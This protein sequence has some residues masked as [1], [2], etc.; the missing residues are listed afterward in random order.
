MSGVKPTRLSRGVWDARV[1]LLSGAMALVGR[2]RAGG[3]SHADPVLSGTGLSGRWGRRAVFGVK[4]RLVLAAVAVVLVGAPVAGV[5]VAGASSAKSRRESRVRYKNVSASKALALL[6]RRLPSAASGGSSDPLAGTRVKRFL[7]DSAAVVQGPARVNGLVESTQPLAGRDPSGAPVALNLDLRAQ[8]GALVGGNVVNAVRIGRQADQG[9][10]L[11]SSGVSFGFAP[12]SASAATVEGPR[13]FFADTATD[14]DAALDVLPNGV[15]LSW[16]LRSAD[17]PTRLPLNFT[18]PAGA[19]VRLDARGSSAEVLSGDRV[20]AVVSPASVQD[21]RGRAV[22]SHFELAGQRLTLVVD[23]T[24]RDLTYPLIADPYI[25]ENWVNQNGD[26]TKNWKT[27]AGLDF[28]GWMAIGGDS[29]V[30]LSQ[31][32]TYNGGVSYKSGLYVAD[33]ALGPDTTSPAEWRWTAPGTSNIYRA[34]FAR[35]VMSGVGCLQEGIRKAD[36]SWE[37]TGNATPGGTYAQSQHPTACAAGVTP[38]PTN[39]PI[40]SPGYQLFCSRASSPCDR[41]TI[42]SLSQGNSAVFGID[43]L[44]AVPSFQVYEMGAAVFLTD[45]DNPMIT[46]A[47]NSLSGAVRTGTGTI[48]ATATDTGLGVK[49]LRLQ[50]PSTTGTPTVQEQDHPCVGDR[51]DRCPATWNT[52]RPNWTPTFAS[53]NV[54]Q[55]PEGLNQFGLQAVDIVANASSGTDA[56][57]AFNSSLVPTIIVDRTP[58]IVAP[59]GPLVD[60]SS[61]AVGAGASSL[62]V[63][64]TDSDPNHATAGVASIE[65]LIDGAD[66]NSTYLYSAPACPS[67]SCNANHTFSVDPSALSLGDHTLTVKAT[68][69]AG[70]QTQSDP[71]TFTYNPETPTVSKTGPASQDGAILRTGQRSFSIN[72]T[73]P[74]SGQMD[75]FG[76][77]SASLTIDGTEFQ[78]LDEPCA[79]VACDLTGSYELDEA[80]LADGLHQLSLQTLDA[81]GNTANSNWTVFTDATPPTLSDSGTLKDAAGSATPGSSYNLHVDATDGSSSQ[82]GSGVKSVSV[83]VDGQQV[84]QRSNADCP[85]RSC[86]SSLDYTYQPSQFAQNQRHAIDVEVT[87]FAGNTTPD[88]FYVNPQP[89]PAISPT[90]CPSGPIAQDPPGVLPVPAPVALTEL[91]AAFPPAVANST[92][93]SVG[94][95]PGSIT[96]AF[97]LGGGGYQSS[98]SLVPAATG[99]AASS[100]V[101]IGFADAPL[102]LIPQG[103]SDNASPAQLVGNDALFYAN[104]YP[105]TDLVRRATA[106]G[107]EDLLALRTAQAPKT[108]QWS[109]SGTGSADALTADGAN[110]VAI[111]H[112]EP[113]DTGAGSPASTADGSPANQNDDADPNQYKPFPPAADSVDVDQTPGIDTPAPGLS[114]FTKSSVNDTGAQVDSLTTELNATQQRAPLSKVLA[115][116]RAAFA[117]DAQGNSVPVSLQSSGSTLT[118]TVSPNSTTVYPILIDPTATTYPPLGAHAANSPLKTVVTHGGP[119]ESPLGCNYSTDPIVATSTNHLHIQGFVKCMAKGTT[120]QGTQTFYV[121]NLRLCARRLSR[122]NLYRDYQCSSASTAAAAQVNQVQYKASCFAGTNS[123]QARITWTFSLPIKPGDPLDINFLNTQNS[124]YLKTDCGDAAAWRKAAGSSPSRT[125]RKNLI[126]AGDVPDAFSKT[127]VPQGYFDAHHIVPT[128]DPTASEARALAYRCFIATSPRVSPNDAK[129][130]VFLRGHRLKSNQHSY[131]YDLDDNDRRLQYHPGLY[132]NEYGMEIT[133][134]LAAAIDS[135]GNCNQNAA[136]QALNNE[137]LLLFAGNA[138]GSPG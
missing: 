114:A 98:S 82:P 24:G 16:Q 89:D 11:G 15:E 10:R 101:G 100:G 99:L 4:G 120:S 87:D 121:K 78:T 93:T 6:D 28:T 118:L 21:A 25:L 62:A 104:A 95:Y 48:T 12:G 117:V 103:T 63:S 59:S 96:P 54:D 3:D 31:Y 42:T 102:C 134:G 116:Y 23:S 76:I 34:E 129:N 9:A 53:Y 22:P 110:Q 39:T 49:K 113:G 85:G 58:P 14:T 45:T 137:R 27:V 75:N 71:Y 38:P 61:G 131:K 57:P 72:A 47:T 2:G 119:Y 115:V 88:Y 123:Y 136:V 13:A 77:A 97:G 36:G 37:D 124:P 33:T 20:L 80:N 55:L 40:G 109:V 66:P 51:N 127:K 92:Q 133:K 122:D 112:S 90:S 5:S 125:L 1:R 56:Q 128:A 107:A 41:T 126:A 60:S 70:N 52:A 65:L 7:S 43:R 32:G 84:A 30:K 132:R 86:P 8:G 135:H 35:P 105:Y 29:Q 74:N 18:L 19:R 73:E 81:A 68:D 138:P 46:A 64:A 106:L 44:T 111:I 17:A 94:I 79:A 50:T 26:Y 83:T 108:F 69:F 91:Q 67:G 130:G